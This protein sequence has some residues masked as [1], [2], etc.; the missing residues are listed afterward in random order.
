MLSANFAKAWPLEPGEGQG[1]GRVPHIL[2]YLEAISVSDEISFY[3]ASPSRFSNLPPC[4]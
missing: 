1:V 4:L 3:Y 2:A